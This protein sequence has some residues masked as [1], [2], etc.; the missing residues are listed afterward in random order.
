MSERLYALFAMT[1]G[2]A[3]VAAGFSADDNTAGGMVALL[4]AVMFAHGLI[5]AMFADR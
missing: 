3:V 2:V 4:G 5:T 1:I